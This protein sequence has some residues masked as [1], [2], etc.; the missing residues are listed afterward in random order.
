[1]TAETYLNHELTSA[2]KK[3]QYDEHA[4]RLLKDKGVLAYILKYAVA[5]F[6]D[7]TIDEAKAAIEGE[8]EVA[9]HEVRPTEAI[10]GI[11][12]E[13]KIPNEG[14]MYFDILFTVVT[15]DSERQKL[16]VNVE[17][18]KSFYPGYDLVPRGIIYT[19]RML[20]EQMD[21]E[22]TAQN[23]DGVKKVYSIWICMN[24]PTTNRDGLDVADTIT[25]YSLQPKS[26]YSSGEYKRQAIGRYDL[27]SVI[28]VNLKD[29]TVESS[30]KLIGMLSTLLSPKIQPDD[31]KVVL[32]ENYNLP[33]TEE[34]KGDA[35]AMCNLSYAIAE[36]AVEEK[37]VELKQKDM[38]LE[39]KDA[40]IKA[41]D[42]EIEQLKAKLAAL[43]K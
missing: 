32:E 33:M 29:S 16:Y 18:Q 10:Q 13:S 14:K 4:R 39:Q 7:Y 35:A 28:F 42:D 11:E 30:N 15:K 20:S 21:K 22:Y 17:A 27:I 8:P 9:S 12:N 19:A 3:A 38:E 6:K 31:K 36:E 43:Q 26:I 23:Y 25:E 2:N 5:E 40:I 37:N 34:M 41:K 24:T 1:M